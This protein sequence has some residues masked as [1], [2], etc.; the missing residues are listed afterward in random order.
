M[1]LPVIIQ[2][3]AELDLA[4]AQLWYETER[5]GLG[6]AFR[7][8]VDRAIGLISSQPDMFPVVLREARR[9][10]RK[11]GLSSWRVSTQN[12]IPSLSAKSSKDGGS[13][14]KVI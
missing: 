10:L 4:V 5:M 3:A 12:E 11:I 8:A 6:T 13:N 1:I 9:V 2:P 7:A 14:R